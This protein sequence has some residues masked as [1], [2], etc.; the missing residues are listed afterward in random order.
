M[1]FFFIKRRRKTTLSVFLFFLFFEWVGGGVNRNLKNIIFLLKI[2][3]TIYIKD[4]VYVISKYIRFPVC[5]AIV[6]IFQVS[7]KLYR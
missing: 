7:F 5:K 6:S 1:K 3:V 4:V 2:S